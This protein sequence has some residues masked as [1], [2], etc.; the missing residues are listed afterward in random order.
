MGALKISFQ[1]RSDRV[2]EQNKLEQK[3]TLT[4]LNLPIFESF[5]CNWMGKS[6]L[7]IGNKC[8]FKNVK[9]N[10]GRGRERETGRQHFFKA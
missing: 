4:K 5:G 8:L 10:R 2:E 6:Q 9:S 1:K 7:N 3:H